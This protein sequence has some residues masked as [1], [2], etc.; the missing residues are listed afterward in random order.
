MKKSKLRSA[1]FYLLKIFSAGLVAVVILTVLMCFYSVTPVHKDNPKGNTDYVWLSNS[2]WVNSTEG[3]SFGKADA[4]GFVNKKVIA[5][6]DILL[7]GSSHIEAKNVMPNKS[8]L[9]VLSKK[10]GDEYSV[11][12]VGM[13]GHHIKKTCQ[14]LSDNIEIF[15]DLKYI[16]IETADV[17]VTQEDVS[18]VLN[19][20]VE[21][22]PSYA[23]GLVGTLQRIPFIYNVYRQMDNGLLDVFLDRTNNTV[24]EENV[25]FD[26]NAYDSIFGYLS[27]IEQ[28]SGAQIIIFY[29]PFESF[30]D[31]GNILFDNNEYTSAFSKAAKKYSIDYI[32]L[33]DDFSNL[34][35]T[36]HKVPHGFVTGKIASGHLNNYGHEI[37]A[38]KVYEII[39]NK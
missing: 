30:D 21:K 14:Y 32:N 13:S 12:N 9:S 37:A 3:L 5:D 35:K 19:H 31:D 6:P 38:E 7:V 28:K 17:T 8:F 18:E 11:Y 24:S 20:N 1:I 2:F 29:H 27:E 36:Q 15:K 22:T 33:A 26:E 10:L 34:Y 25:A 4:D 39:K 16:V 23:G